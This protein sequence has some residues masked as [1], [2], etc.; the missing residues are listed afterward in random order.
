MN[1]ANL[2]NAL[3]RISPTVENG[4]KE[5]IVYDTTT[6]SWHTVTSV[7]VTSNYIIVNVIPK[8][9]TQTHDK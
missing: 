3:D 8:P 5:V 9:E 7:D 4:L 2:L 1:L 6:D